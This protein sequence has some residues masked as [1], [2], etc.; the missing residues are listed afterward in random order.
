[1]VKQPPSLALSIYACPVG[2]AARYGQLQGTPF[3]FE[4]KERKNFFL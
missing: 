4:K 1:M 2:L 3:S